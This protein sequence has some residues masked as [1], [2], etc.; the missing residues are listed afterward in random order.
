MSGSYSDPDGV[1]YN[2][3]PWNHYNSQFEVQCVFCANLDCRLHKFLVNSSDNFWIKRAKE[4]FHWKIIR[5]NEYHF[6]IQTSHYQEPWYQLASNPYHLARKMRQINGSSID[7]NVI[8]KTSYHLITDYSLLS[9]ILMV[10][11][12]WS[13]IET[14]KV[15]S[16]LMG[17]AGVLS[18]FVIGNFLFCKLGVMWVRMKDSESQIWLLNLR[19]DLQCPIPLHLPL[20]HRHLHFSL[21]HH[22][23]IPFHRNPNISTQHHR[24]HRLW[25]FQIPLV[26]QC[27]C[28]ETHR[29]PGCSGLRVWVDYAISFD[30]FGYDLFE[31]S[32]TSERSELD[33]RDGRDTGWCGACSHTDL[34]DVSLLCLQLGRHT[35]IFSHI[36]THLG[37]KYL[38]I[39]NGLIMIVIVLIWL[40]SIRKFK[41]WW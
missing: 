14:I 39:I 4:Y 38:W 18:L 24:P 23:P 36:Y 3:I 31:S 28:S 20:L 2:S 25:P 6:Q 29:I 9:I 35:S 8:T 37:L 10:E 11:Y 26:L 13:G 30:I 17:G 5:I 12:G 27:S 41:P 32:G 33:A 15:T 19:I 1:H 21:R 22:L 16:V 7:C 40:L 34:C